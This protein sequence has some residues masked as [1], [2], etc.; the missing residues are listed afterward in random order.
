MLQNSYRKVGFTMLTDLEK[1]ALEDT[2]KEG[3][4]RRALQQR[5]ENYLEKVLESIITEEEKG[6]EGSA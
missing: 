4:D 3:S 5:L 1:K 2:V 6:D